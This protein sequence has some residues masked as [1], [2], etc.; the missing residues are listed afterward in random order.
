MRRLLA[1]IDRAVDAMAR[2]PGHAGGSDP[3][4]IVS[5]L[6]EG[7]DRLAVEQAPV[8]WKLFAMLPMPVV[9]YEDDFPTEA[10]LEQFRTMLAA[11]DRIQVLPC[12]DGEAVSPGP[13]RDRQYE[14]LGSALVRQVD[15]LLAVWDGQPAAGP[16]GT[17]TVIGEATARGVPVI[18]VD[19]AH[20]D[21]PRLLDAAGR[22]DGDVLDA[23]GLRRL[24][25]GLVR[26]ARDE[27][28]SG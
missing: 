14:A 16:G 1:D 4:W 11:A 23:A 6:A 19:P 27:S 13:A 12:L 5:G 17:Q 24:L 21:A 3:I 9:S 20:P 7:A 18:L 2:S 10:A 28:R 26:P 8:G 15:L 25:E 22:S